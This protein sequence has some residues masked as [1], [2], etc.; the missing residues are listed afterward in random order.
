[1]SPGQNNSASEDVENQSDSEFRNDKA[2]QNKLSDEEIE[3][4][5][6]FLS[7]TLA[8]CNKLNST[9]DFDD[10]IEKNVGRKKNMDELK[11]IINDNS[12]ATPDSL[13]I[14]KLCGRIA[15]SMMQCQ[16]YQEY[17]DHFRKSGFESS[18]SRASE[19]MSK[20]ESWMLY[21]GTDFGLKKTVRPLISDIHLAHKSN[22]DRALQE[23]LAMYKGPLPAEIIA[24]LTATFNLDDEEAEE[25]DLALAGMVGE[26]VGEPEDAAEI[27]VA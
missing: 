24:A 6:A 3:I 2:N 9:D 5:E 8:I 26:G 12:E 18:L 25:M 20:L 1:M 22:L 23:Y 4:Q 11:S 7:L 16:Q 17:A 10:T 27:T 15:E 13:R 21:I 14:V 19:T